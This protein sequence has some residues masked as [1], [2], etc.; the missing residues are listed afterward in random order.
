[1]TIRFTCAQCGSVLKIKD[2]LAGTDGRC[3]K[4]KTPFVVPESSSDEPSAKP[5]PSE[6]SSVAAG[7]PSSGKT[8][9][10]DETRKEPAG[11]E[12]FDPADFLMS[13]DSGPPRRRATSFA[14]DDK[15]DRSPSDDTRREVLGKK[16]GSSPTPATDGKS[17]AA[18]AASESSV[19]ASSHAKQLMVKTMEQSRAHAAEM[20][21]EEKPPGFDFAGMFRELGLKGG[22]AILIG[23]VLT[24]GLYLAFD[25]MMGTS[26]KLPPLAYV[27]GTIKLDGKPL[28]GA[29]V[30][31]A[32]QETAIGDSKRERA[33]T[34]I[35]I[36]NEQGQYKLIYIDKV[37]G[38]AVGKCRVW[39]DLVGP[40]GQ[41]IPPAYSE[42][43][44]MVRE[45]ATGSQT[46]DFDMKSE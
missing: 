7:G 37:Q 40:T 36:A 45:V 15:P 10:R 29:T 39:L 26:L 41:V 42:G 2:E 46:I 11:D 18:D 38:V 24:Y 35:G 1:M 27:S 16:K 43:Q 33:R 14:L 12:P 17:L 22:G 21:E 34:S 30:Y 6:S 8:K 25:R 23:C 31:F 19:N 9:P 32:P 4:C 44:L 13:D 20:P 3:P 28:P 5:L